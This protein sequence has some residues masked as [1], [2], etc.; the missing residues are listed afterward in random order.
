MA[1]SAY[2]GKQLNGDLG[3]FL[4]AV[5]ADVYPVGTVL[6]VEAIDRLG[7][8]DTS[9]MI[10]I[11][12]GIIN[13]G[14]S[15]V[16]L[17]DGMTYNVH[18]L[19]GGALYTFSGK[20]QQAHDYSE[21]LSKRIKASWNIKK[22]NAKEHGIRPIFGFPFWL[23]KAGELK[24]ECQPLLEQ[25]FTDYLSGLGQTRIAERLRFDESGLLPA[26]TAKTV[27]KTL[28]N[29]MVIGLWNEAEVFPKAISPTLFYQVQE[30]LKKRSFTPVVTPR[31]LFFS[32]IAKCECGT[33]LTFATDFKRG[34][35]NSRCNKR[36]RRKESCDNSRSIAYKVFEYI[37]EQCSDNWKYLLLERQ[38]Q[39][40]NDSELQALDGLITA[41]EAKVNKVLD[42]LIETP[43]QRLQK[44]LTDIESE[45]EKQIKQRHT[46][47]VE[48][49]LAPDFITTGEQEL[50]ND[51]AL[52]SSTLIK[53][54][55]EITSHKDGTLAVNFDDVQYKY[56]V[57]K[58]FKKNGVSAYK[59]RLINHSLNYCTWL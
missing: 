13:A 40:D 28:A 23:D 53:C 18:A 11:L 5:K 57:L 24:P 29:E 42:I 17:E 22:K 31:A 8:T 56:E 47:T 1:L 32:G 15:I 27:K 6:L 9:Q 55:Y 45:L 7:R 50:L 10:H 37:H 58:G 36:T 14:I 49:T 19:N 52:L 39:T 59:T 25:M 48:T 46:L 2:H 12:T 43:S 51:E 34:Y 54:N 44:R 35:T 26:I 4:E 41:L 33:N 16:T 21:K 3:L 30:E 20:I 38:Q